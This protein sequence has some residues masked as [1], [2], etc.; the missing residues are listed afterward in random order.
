[1]EREKIIDKVRKL[2]AQADDSSTT[3]QEAQAFA[4]MVQRLL[5]KHKLAMS[6]VQASGETQ[7]PVGEHWVNYKDAGI[8]T[9]NSRVLWQ[10]LLAQSVS[11]AYFCEVLT[12]HRSNR[13]ILVGKK[14]DAEV[15]EYVL[16]T[17]IRS[18]DKMS[19]AAT[20]RA[21]KRGIRRAR[22]RESWIRGFVQRLDRRLEDELAQAMSDE[23]QGTD[24]TALVVVRKEH[25]AVADFMALQRYGKGAR[26]RGFGNSMNMEGY[27]EGQ[28]AANNVDIHGRA[29]KDGSSRKPK[30]QLR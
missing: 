28:Q 2:Q 26:L 19:H 3:E 23:S 24:C 1:M 17:L 6:D 25:K 16:T 15:A 30:G 11:K 20:R 22:Y 18:V 12:V 9:V 5:L 27:R 14:S 29:I 21:V 8:K 7:E 4:A 13:L 10:I